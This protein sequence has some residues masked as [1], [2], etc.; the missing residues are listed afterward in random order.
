MAEMVGKPLTAEEMAV[1]LAEKALCEHLKKKSIRAKMAEMVG[2]PLTAEELAGLAEEEAELAVKLADKIKAR[3]LA[4]KLAKQVAEMPKQLA[5]EQLVGKEVR[6]KVGTLKLE[7]V[8]IAYEPQV[9]F[10]AKPGT[11]HK[12]SLVLT[13]LKPGDERTYALEIDEKNPGVKVGRLTEDFTW[14]FPARGMS[15]VAAELTLRGD[16]VALKN[17]TVLSPPNPLLN[18]VLVQTAGNDKFKEIG[19]FA[20]VYLQPNDVVFLGDPQRIDKELHEEY[21]FSVKRSAKFPTRTV[22][23]KLAEDNVWIDPG[24]A[25]DP[26]NPPAKR[27]HHLLC[28]IGGTKADVKGGVQDFQKRVNAMMDRDGSWTAAPGGYIVVPLEDVTEIVPFG[29]VSEI[30]APSLKRKV[31]E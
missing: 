13:C 28:K 3:Q 15:R 16:R 17:I 24:V 18:K 19:Q 22:G 29:A 26:E 8:A 4:Y 30:A 31:P 21:K 9:Y 5:G 11:H 1:G 10:S 25:G 27:Y 20:E 2:K 14:P 12:T 7:A 6:V 23:H